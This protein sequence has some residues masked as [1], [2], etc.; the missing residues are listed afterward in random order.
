MKDFE[1][2]QM[3]LCNLQ[4]CT[5]LSTKAATDRANAECP[6]GIS[7]R[8]K[9]SKKKGLAPVACQDNPETHRHIILEC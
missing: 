1:I 2:T 5:C 3:G 7:S 8:W 9:P 6:T 4:V